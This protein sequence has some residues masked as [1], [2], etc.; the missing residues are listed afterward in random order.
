MAKGSDGLRSLSGLL[1]VITFVCV[2]SAVI[3]YVLLARGLQDAVNWAQLILAAPGLFMVVP[4]VVTWFRNRRMP[5]PSCGS[6]ALQRGPLTV[7]EVPQAAA[8]LELR[9]ELL[10]MLACGDTM[11]ARGIYVLTGARGS[12]KTQLAGAYARRCQSA[13]WRLVAWVNAAEPGS[14]LTG[15]AAV[16]R[17]LELPAD[18]GDADRAALLVRYR[19]ESDGARCLVV[20]DDVADLACLRRYL[21]SY[22]DAQVVITTTCQEAADLGTP[23]PV[24]MFTMAEASHFLARRAGLAEQ[25]AARDLA[26]ELGCLPLALAHAA[27]LIASQRLDYATFLARLRQ[28]P[29]RKCLTRAGL[30]P[31]PRGT[32]EAVDLTLQTV[33]VKDETGTC[34]AV[35]D[36]IAVLSQTGTQRWILRAAVNHLSL[37]V[38]A[39]RQYRWLPVTPDGVDAALGQLSD[40]SLLTFGEDNSL[41][42]AHKMTARVVRERQAADGTAPLVEAT[43]VSLLS[44]LMAA[45]EQPWEDRARVRE[46]AD[47]VDAL[48]CHA[49]EQLGRAG[50][51]T[52]LVQL[53]ARAVELLS[54]LGD[55]PAGVI[56]L[57][58]PLAGAC[59]RVLGADHPDTF[60]VRSH[61]ARAYRMAGR[62]DKAIDLFGRLLTDCRRW[63]GSDHPTTLAAQSD[64]AG[65]YE[66]VGRLADA[67]PLYSSTLT[68]REHVLGLDHPDTL[69]SRH[70]LAFASE[71]EWRLARLHQ[72]QPTIYSPARP[73]A[74][75]IPLYERTLE[76]RER[77]L[78]SDHPS[79]LAGRKELI[80]NRSADRRLND[81][82]RL[83]RC[84]LAK[85]TAVLG[86]DHPD[87]LATRNNLAS[88]LGSA[89]QP[90]V[91]LDQFEQ[92]LA[93]R[94]QVLGPDHPDTLD[95]R[96]NLAYMYQA[97]GRLPEAIALYEQNLSD[98]E[99]AL[100][101]ENAETLAFCDNLAFA[102][103]EAGDLAHAIPLY[104]RAT[105]DRERELGLQHPI[106]VIS[107]KNLAL[108]CHAARKGFHSRT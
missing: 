1:S 36:L 69:A 106:T 65:A 16:A 44:E 22:G 80:T 70:N 12:G 55:D 64:L 66:S 97:T 3:F 76:N 33:Q 19:L 67:I 84:C 51:A 35:L 45:V 24:G 5:S 94:K 27:A 75:R 17:A 42:R 10:E 11:G 90:D 99:R 32:Y 39:G 62:T 13:G 103:L 20:F 21:P 73:H 89:G 71:S 77:V 72:A 8:A 104:E 107:R 74:E 14:A 81:A 57:G 96:N 60:A 78:G 23:V 38:C 54:R 9:P 86:P 26:A 18:G 2:G 48:R 61:L 29:V 93:G 4:P 40:A 49:G 37:P 105:D 79:V 83:N 91:A 31:Y 101:G 43:A 102:Y 15:L 68:A 59:E 6:G 100:G 95:T 50:P 41:V 53:Q 108:A 34:A 85:R 56:R 25:A 82:L 7:G 58:E 30:D 98:S 92:T 88:T 52:G 47:H 28:L 46:L 87:T 63:Y